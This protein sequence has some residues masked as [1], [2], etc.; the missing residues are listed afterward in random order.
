M[1]RNYLYNENVKDSTGS[2]FR[3]SVHFFFAQN[4]NEFVNLQKKTREK[5][6]LSVFRFCHQCELARENKCN[7]VLV[8]YRRTL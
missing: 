1:K 7:S 8:A 5:K 6:N 2:V 3:L 4:K